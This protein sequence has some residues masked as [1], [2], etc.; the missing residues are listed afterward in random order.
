MANVTIAY[1]EDCGACRWT[2]ERLRRWD[3]AGRLAFVPIQDADDLL[4]GLVGFTYGAGAPGWR[5][6]AL[7]LIDVLMDG[8]KP[9]G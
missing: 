5:E 7:R 4:R 1:D 2:A 8:M 3:R 6:S 9:V